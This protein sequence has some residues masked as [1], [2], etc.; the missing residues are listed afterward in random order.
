MELND[1][2][3]PALVVIQREG[4]SCSPRESRSYEIF[5]VRSKGPDFE[6]D[7]LSFN[8]GLPDYFCETFSHAS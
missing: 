3:F 5:E 7:S 8:P 2:F 4:H 1:F 6:S